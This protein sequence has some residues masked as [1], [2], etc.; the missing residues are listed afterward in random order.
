[1][2][3]ALAVA[4]TTALV[5]LALAFLASETCSADDADANLTDN[6]LTAG[7]AR[8]ADALNSPNKLRAQLPTWDFPSHSE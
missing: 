4:F 8:L 5:F 3:T 7:S 2:V 6:A 1:M